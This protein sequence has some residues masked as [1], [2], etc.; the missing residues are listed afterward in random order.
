MHLAAL[1]V[2]GTVFTSLQQEP[3]IEA[4]IER[5]RE[6]HRNR[7]CALQVL[8]AQDAEWKASVEPLT[9]TDL[10]GQRIIALGAYKRASKPGTVSYQERHG[11]CTLQAVSRSFSPSGT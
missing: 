7:S 3:H 9:L 8:N 2:G 10:A 6:A 4:P 5:Y 1:M 11:F